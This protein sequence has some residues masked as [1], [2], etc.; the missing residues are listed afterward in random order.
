MFMHLFMIAALWNLVER[1]SCHLFFTHKIVEKAA[2]ERVVVLDLLSFDWSKVLKLPLPIRKK[3]SHVAAQRRLL[4][5]AWPRANWNFFEPVVFLQ[6]SPQFMN[7]AVAILWLSIFINKTCG[8][9]NLLKDVLLLSLSTPCSTWYKVDFIMVFLLLIDSVKLNAAKAILT[10][11]LHVL[12]DKIMLI[13]RNQSIPL[14]VFRLVEKV[15]R[16]WNATTLRKS[17][18]MISPFLLQF[19]MLSSLSVKNALAT[20]AMQIVYILSINRIIPF[21]KWNK[22]CTLTGCQM[23]HRTWTLWGRLKRTN[24]FPHSAWYAILFSFV[25]QVHLIRRDISIHVIRFHAFNSKHFACKEWNCFY[26]RKILS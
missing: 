25:F 4:I 12:D 20:P 10:Q 21:I 14:A 24:R 8:E 9:C 13:I 19:H 26:S 1:Q 5:P 6:Q 7:V 16:T 23:L 17:S 11:T 2:C 18:T 15:N 22:S 3:N